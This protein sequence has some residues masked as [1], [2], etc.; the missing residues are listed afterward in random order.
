MDEKLRALQQEGDNAVNPV[1][2]GD[3]SSE[4][5]EQEGGVQKITDVDTDKMEAPQDG[6]IFSKPLPE[7][8]NPLSGSVSIDNVIVLDDGPVVITLKIRHHFTRKIKYATIKLE[9]LT[10]SGLKDCVTKNGG[11]VSDWDALY[12]GLMK[13]ISMC[14]LSNLI[15][16]IYGHTELG[17][18]KSADGIVF[19]HQQKISTDNQNSEYCGDRDIKPKGSLDNLVNMINQWILSTPEWSPLEA[20]IAFSVSAVVLPFALYNWGKTMNNLIL[21]LVGDSTT[22]KSTAL[23][24]HVGLASNPFNEKTGFWLNHQSSL[25]AIIRR[26][27]NNQGLP[28]G[29][30]ELSSASK[31]DYT[32]FVYAL[33]NG[34]EK[35]R[36]KAGGIGLYD[37]ASFHTIPVSSGENS[38]LDKCNS[39]SG[40]RARCVEFCN[41]MWTA[42]KEQAEAIGECLKNNY[43]WVA[44]LIAKEL[45][46][47]S[48]KWKA[49]WEQLYKQ[50]NNRMDKDKIRLAIG[51]R[52]SEFVVLFTL[53]AKIANEVLGVSLN[54]NG[55]YDF[56][57]LHIITV[58]A[59][60]SNL[61]ERAYEYLIRY[62]SRNPEEFKENCESFIGSYSAKTNVK[63]FLRDAKRSREINGKIYEQQIVFLV[64]A[65]ENILKAGGFSPKVVSSELHKAHF[66]QVHDQNRYTLPISYNNFY[67]NCYVLYCRREDDMMYQAW[68]DGKYNP[69]GEDDYVM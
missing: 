65:Y 63:G 60:E 54:V 49:R 38:I 51:A 34:V 37:S 28:V 27:G 41:V 56:C 69:N 6:V 29:I 19:C 2:A 33:G 50:I 24:L 35:D 18:H 10:P 15:P 61:R 62:V 22:G 44:P 45:L 48:D 52:I 66:L 64:D 1:V 30:D 36:S 53:A 58:N 17:W 40:T 46:N 47:N 32:N 26:I 31:N 13:S 11:M 4:S 39:N 55:V 12:K 20:V 59:A 7:K 16:I 43:G 3:Q 23:R 5:A 68:Y 21:H 8:E 42:S 14:W 25:A 9:E 57:Y 67:Q